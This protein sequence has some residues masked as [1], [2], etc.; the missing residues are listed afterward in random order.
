M[1]AMIFIVVLMV[2]TVAS[3]ELCMQCSRKKEE[4]VGPQPEIAGD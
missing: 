2:V 1:F 4:S 3:F